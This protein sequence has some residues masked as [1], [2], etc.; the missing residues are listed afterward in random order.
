[1]RIVLA[2]GLALLALAAL[3]FVVAGIYITISGMRARRGVKGDIAL[4]GFFV[5]CFVLAAGVSALIAFP[6][7]TEPTEVTSGGQRQQTSSPEQSGAKPERS[8]GEKTG[9]EA[10]ARA[11][12]PVTPDPSLAL[13]CKDFTSQGAAQ[14]AFD[15]QLEDQ[16]ALDP[17]ADGT[18]CEALAV[19]DPKPKPDLEKQ[20]KKESEPKKRSESKKKPEPGKEPA[21]KKK[22]QR[23]EEPEPEK[24]R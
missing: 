21:P 4:T 18:A 7:S 17:D 23:E 19:P 1:M 22:P 6:N 12:P 13:G 5:V 24:K 9:D 8:A 11:E 14:K 16:D 2:V 15:Q 3:F 10:I 20:P